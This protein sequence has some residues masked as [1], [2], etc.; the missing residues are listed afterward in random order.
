MATIERVNIEDV[1]PLE[2]E[3]GNDLASR[4]YSKKV[5]QEYVHQLARSMREK[6]VPD[7]MVTLVRDG[8]IYRIKAGNS[9]VMAMRELGT[10][11]FQAIVED[12]ST[13][14]EVI[15]TVIRTNTKKKYEPEE[16]SCF[17][18]QLAMFATDE[19]VAEVTGIDT[20][21]VAKI[22]KAAKVVDDSADDMSLLRLI[23]IGEFADDPE[24]VETLTNCS[25]REYQ[26]IARR[27]RERKKKQ[28]SADALASE[29]EA[30]GIPQVKSPKGLRL[31]ANVNKVSQLPEN[32]PEGTVAMPHSV[33]GFYMLLA[34]MEAEQTA[35]QQQEDA[36]RA[37]AE[38]M[39]ALHLEGTMRRRKWLAKALE[40]PGGL[41]NLTKRTEEWRE[42]YPDTVD[43]FCKTTCASLRVGPSDIV[44]LFEAWNDSRHNG[45]LDGAGRPRFYACETYVDLID[46]ME[47]DGY[48]PS[49]DEWEIYRKAQKHLEG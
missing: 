27:L 17:V 42:R 15:E 7:E 35:Q 32:L 9:R 14:Q 31:V 41:L 34:P 6:G 25:E 1:F 24:A 37:E 10:K 38:A 20:K 49:E 47:S 46:L 3:F 29:L 45:I 4:D 33:Q 11:S 39:A 44:R 5:N 48:E 26:T 19:H 13:L 40:R 8:G 18:R 30:A 36:G 12:E 16:E 2:D 22:R 28:Q 23:T 21:D 43:E